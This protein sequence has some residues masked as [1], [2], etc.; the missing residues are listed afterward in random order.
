VDRDILLAI[1]AIGPQ[2]VIFLAVAFL[3]ARYRDSIS[4]LVGNRVTSVSVFGF[5]VD[6][7]PDQVDEAVKNRAPRTD[8]VE[9]S[10]PAH[11]G[12]SSQL[13]A[14]A[15]RLADRLNGRTLLWVDDEQE[16]NRTERRMLRSTGIFVETATS[17]DQALRVLDD[18]SETISLVISDIRRASGESGLDLVQSIAQRPHAPRVVLYIGKVDR[19][20]PA[21][22]GVFGVADRPDDL[23][24]LVMDALDRLD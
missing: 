13:V 8:A 3:G 19:D 24:N 12:T 11:H 22:A 6:L 20:R 16:N 9:P 1:I 7:Q 23:L 5:K 2:L 14:R 10:P 15:N 17:N 21:P 18:P 4:R